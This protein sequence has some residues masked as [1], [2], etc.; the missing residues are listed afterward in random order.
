[1]ALGDAIE[2]VLLRNRQTET[3]DRDGKPCGPTLLACSCCG[4][5][6]G[7]EHRRSCYVWSNKWA[8]HFARVRERASYGTGPATRAV[9]E[10]RVRLP[11]VY[12]PR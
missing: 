4:A 11:P 12:L 9:K 1:M 8:A 7:E 5:G 6:R 2:Q 10:E 3:V